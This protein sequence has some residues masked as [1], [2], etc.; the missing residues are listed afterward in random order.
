MLKYINYFYLLTNVN[1]Y[2]YYIIYSR[3]EIIMIFNETKTHEITVV[4]VI[5]TLQNNA[6][7]VLLV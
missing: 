5:L 1:F 4:V 2:V 6:L 7:H 3:V